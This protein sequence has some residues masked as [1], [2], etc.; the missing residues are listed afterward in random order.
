[1]WP[2]YKDIQTVTEEIPTTIRSNINRLITMAGGLFLIYVVNNLDMVTNGLES[3]VN[4]SGP[5]MG[6]LVA[7]VVDGKQN[8]YSSILKAAA[9]DYQAYDWGKDALRVVDGESDNTYKKTKTPIIVTA[10]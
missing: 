10:K 1:M 2:P 8:S 6:R 9:F 4:G 3:W 7:S 5:A